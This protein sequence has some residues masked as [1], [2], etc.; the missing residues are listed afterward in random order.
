MNRFLLILLFA[1]AGCQSLPDLS[2]E[3][4]FAS[5]VGK[6]VALVEEQVVVQVPKEISSGLLPRW[7]VSVSEY[8]HM[9]EK[10]EQIASLKKGDRIRLVRLVRRPIQNDLFPGTVLYAICEIGDTTGPISFELIWGSSGNL[11]R[12]PWEPKDTPE[13]RRFEDG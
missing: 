3:Q 12:A 9:K 8:E 13:R 4:P 6:E 10:V 7:L 11:L 5:Y 1:L 2:K